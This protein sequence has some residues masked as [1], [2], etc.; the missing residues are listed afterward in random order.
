MRKQTK[1]VAVLSAAALLAIGAS[2]T[3]FA[4]TGWQEE[5]GTWVYYDKNGDMVT[6][7]WAKSGDNWFY[8]DGAGEMATD[9]LIEDGDNYYYVDENGAMTTN[10]WIAIDNEDAG[11]DN[12]PQSWWYYFQA[13]GKAMKGPDDNKV[14]LK[15]ING[16]KYAFNSDAKMLYGWIKSDDATIIN[17][18]DDAWQQGTYYFGD[19]NDGS[20]AVGWKLLEIT[21][22]DADTDKQHWVNPAFIDDEEQSRWFYF[23]SNGKKTQG[24]SDE[25]KESTINGKK[26]GFDEFGR[27]VG[28]WSAPDLSS[29]TA[30]TAADSSEWKY[31]SSVESGAR[32]TKGWF[33]VVPPENLNS[34]DYDDDSEGWY[35]AD[36]NGN[37]YAGELKTIKGKKYGFNENGKMLD[38]LKFLKVNGNTIEE[39]VSDDTYENYKFDTE[40]GYVEN[41]GF[42]TAA[43]YSSYYFGD[44]DDGSMKT[45]KVTLTIDG[46]KFN[47]NFGKSGSSKGA[48]KVGIEDKKIY[49]AGKLVAAGKDE[50]YQ[51]VVS[52]IFSGATIEGLGRL[53]TLEDAALGDVYAG[54]LKLSDSSK[55]VDWASNVSFTDG[56][57]TAVYAIDS[58]DLANDTTFA[59][60]ELAAETGI[61]L[62]ALKSATGLS[63]ND[64]YEEIKIFVT[65]KTT[66][67]ST[68][69][70]LG[71]PKDVYSIVNTSGKVSEKSSKNK[72]GDDTI[73]KLNDGK[74]VATYIEN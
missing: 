49:D 12:E 33:K 48:G 8:L 30:S 6:D 73:Y 32:I 15:T 70:S 11:N 35:Y 66:D 22:V 43:G 74:I 40:D 31:F 39:I 63:N 69:Y 10:R 68:T 51:P 56:T 46:D 21:D 71:L 59:E 9:Q 57:K 16:K 1:L 2:M 13:N 36:N 14:A 50:K 60:T 53:S 58:S 38:G 19:E 34:G 67:T 55:L 24:T 23:K 64:K 7:T 45:G 62:K 3:S 52:G 72:D 18:D 5:N 61:T 44:G 25:L 54:Y 26:Y 41:A 20:M 65:S 29:S 17:D 27:M 37:I 4:A 47:F 42:Y 28:E